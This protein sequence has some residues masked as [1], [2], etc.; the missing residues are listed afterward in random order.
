MAGLF[1][2]PVTWAAVPLVQAVETSINIDASFMHQQYHEN[3]HPVGDVEN[4]YMPGFGVNISSLLP[5]KPGYSPD[6]YTYLGYDFNAG[7]IHYDGHYIA[8][9]APA[10]AT[11]NAVFQ[12]I[13]GRIGAGFPLQGGA[14]VIPFVMGGYQAWNRNVNQKGA[15]ANDEFY[16]SGLFGLGVKLDV[17]VTPTVVISGTGEIIGLAGG[18]ITAHGINFGR[19]FG[20]T[21]EERLELAV[22]DQFT[23]RWHA[24]GSAYWEHFNYSG[25]HPEYY[26]DEG[27]A[28]EP[29]STTTQFGFTVGVGYSFD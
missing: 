22:T 25:T 3:L 19:G 26:G 11:D 23:P 10:V 9:G 28:Y 8:S 5:V 20:V 15:I 24:T 7:D 2:V 21:P 14:E 6:L 18:G 4:G 1:A 27:Y 12:R 17:P 29:F 16:H 13:E